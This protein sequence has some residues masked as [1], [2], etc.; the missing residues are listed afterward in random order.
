MD[1]YQTRADLS[2]VLGF[3]VTNV[4]VSV[5]PCFIKTCKWVAEAFYG[6]EKKRVSAV[7]EILTRSHSK[8][9]L[10]PLFGIFGYFT[11]S[12]YQLIQE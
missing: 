11:K 4:S 1:T 8:Q 5:F 9:G 6:V 7:E 3:T 2:P 12:T 10:Q